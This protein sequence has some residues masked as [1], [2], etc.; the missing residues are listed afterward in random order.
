MRPLDGIRVLELGQVIAGP[1]ASL[2]LADLGAEVI[3]V[4]R[5]GTGDSARSP[6]VTGVAGFSGAFATFNRNKRS[7]TLDLTDPADYHA[8]ARLVRT[9]DV[10]LYNYPPAVARKLRIDPQ[11]LE[12]INPRVITCAISGFREGSPHADLPSYDLVHQA[13]T[14]YLLL[15]GREED[16]PVRFGIPLAD[17]A[18]ALFAAYGTLGALRKRDQTG[19]GE[20]VSVSMYDSLISLL[21]YQATMFFLTG[22]E[23][24]RMGSAHEFV[25]PWQAF[26][27][28]DGHIVIAARANHFWRAFCEAVGL[29]ELV[30]DPRFADNTRRL[31]HRDELE[32]LLDNHLRQ[33]STAEWMAVLVPAG[34]PAAP[35]RSVGEALT[36]PHLAASGMVQE[37]QHPAIGTVRLV[38]NPVRFSSMATVTPQPPPE[39][40][41]DQWLVETTEANGDGEGG[42]GSDAS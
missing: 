27:T 21:T 12:A 26:R 4:E 11:S 35:V 30:T 28:A 22:Q 41:A 14:G 33:R 29:P 36:D 13:F 8:F 7:V 5:P 23:P 6:D 19:Q 32:S 39:L 42:T 24:A 17:L 37:Y 3:K 25:M 31:A 18:T 1:Y 16:P 2:L 34:V 20:T 38:A 9:A 10:V 40:G 15:S